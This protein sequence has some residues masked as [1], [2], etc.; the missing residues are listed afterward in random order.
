MRREG[1]QKERGINAV[2]VQC[3]NTDAGR[4]G[5]AA[6][7]LFC[8]VYAEPF[9][10]RACAAYFGWPFFHFFTNKKPE[11]YS[12]F[13]ETNMPII[14]KADNWERCNLWNLV[15]LYCRD[16]FHTIFFFL[17]PSTRLEA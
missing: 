16:P 9:G 5:F 10:R 15:F 6:E 17:T 13:A 2:D 8:T 1:C 11:K 4:A 14:Y 3:G 12:G 7:N